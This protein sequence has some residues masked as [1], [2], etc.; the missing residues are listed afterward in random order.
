[1]PTLVV[2]LSSG[3]YFVDAALA[4]AE[5]GVMSV[6]R[7]IR[8]LVDGSSSLLPW[9]KSLAVGLTRVL[10]STCLVEF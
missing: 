7:E 6:N 5:I 3:F 10:I 1:M 2:W 8:E 4:L 9:L